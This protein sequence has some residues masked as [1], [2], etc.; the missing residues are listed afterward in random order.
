MNTTLL[1]FVLLYLVGTMGIGIYAGTRI[2][3]T[4]VHG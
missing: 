1:A 4:S 2:Q 3:N